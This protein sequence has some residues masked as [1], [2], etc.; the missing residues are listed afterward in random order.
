ME[1]RTFLP[2]CSYRCFVAAMSAL[3]V[4]DESSKPGAEQV[5]KHFNETDETFAN[6]GQGWMVTQRL[7]RGEGRFPYCVA[8]FR[9]S[10]DELEPA[11]GQF[12][13]RLIDESH[14][15]LGQTGRAD[16]L[17]HHDRQRHTK[18]YYCSPKWLFD[19]GCR[20]YDY[21]EGGDRHFRRRPIKRVEPDYGDPLF[22]KEHG[23]FIARW[24]STTTATRPSSSSTSAPMASGASGTQSTRSPGRSASRSSTC[25]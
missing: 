6:P 21:T 2:V 5:I 7:P 13:W 1:R 17:S 15:G 20:G 22:L 25:T 3:A 24:P 16:R 9:L 14:P 4:A 8:Y 10:W 12:D 11:Q 18:G 23:R 19:A